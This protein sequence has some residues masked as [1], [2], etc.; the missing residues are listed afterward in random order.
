MD[1]DPREG[2]EISL[3]ELTSTGRKCWAPSRAG[4]LFVA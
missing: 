3:K 1:R 4:E 2:W